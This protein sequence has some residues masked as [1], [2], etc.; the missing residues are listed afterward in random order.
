MTRILIAGCEQEISTFHP[1][2][3][4]YDFFDVLFGAEVLEAN[5][6][7]NTTIGGA[8][9]EFESHEGVELISTYHAEGSAAGPLDVRNAIRHGS[10]LLLKS[11]ALPMASVMCFSAAVL[12]QS[13]KSDPNRR[14][15]PSPL[16][17]ER[18]IMEEGIRPI[19]RRTEKVRTTQGATYAG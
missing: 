17:T 15:A 5:L 7:K 11:G 4:A 14:M 12:M 8:A 9:A 16:K 3:C 13:T 10:N 2:P 18:S 1:V 6:G 19:N